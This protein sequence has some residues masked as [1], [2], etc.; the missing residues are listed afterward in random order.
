MAEC[1]KH[2][3][4]EPSHTQLS[5]QPQPEHECNFVI[6]AGD[7]KLCDVCYQP[8]LG[9]SLWWTLLEMA[10]QEIVDPQ[11]HESQGRQ[12]YLDMNPKIP[13]PSRTVVN[14]KPQLATQHNP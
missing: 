14:P 13:K 11:K 6:A 1:P 5:H 4:P 9:T 8:P 10:Q 3:C 12:Q 2:V 7:A